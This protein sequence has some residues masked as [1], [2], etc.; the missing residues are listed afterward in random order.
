MTN[1]PPMLERRKHSQRFFDGS[2]R[3]LANSS[4]PQVHDIKP[5]EPK[6][7]EI[8]MNG[9]DQFLTRKSM[10]PGFVRFAP[11]ADLGDDHQVIR[12]RMERLPDDLIGHVGTI[13]VAGI[14]MVHTGCDRLSQNSDCAVN[15]SRWSPYL[16]TRKFHRAVAHAV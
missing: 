4:D 7:S 1:H 9:I 5:I 3:W 13:K 10:R 14:D 2:F 8:V 16:R 6:I 11:S 15:I 12:V